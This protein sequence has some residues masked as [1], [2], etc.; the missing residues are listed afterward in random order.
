MEGR[1]ANST[2]SNEKNIDFHPSN[3]HEVRVKV[4]FF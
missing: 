1:S 2:N 4:K 3:V